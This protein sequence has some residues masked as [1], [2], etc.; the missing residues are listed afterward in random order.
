V[1]KHSERGTEQ[2]WRKAGAGSGWVLWE[3]MWNLNCIVAKMR[4]Y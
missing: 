1:V 4:I 3:I 2:N